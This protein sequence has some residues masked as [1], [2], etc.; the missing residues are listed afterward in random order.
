MEDR[1]LLSGTPALLDPLMVP[2]FVNALP[3]PL[4]PSFVYQ[5]TI[6]A[7]GTPHYE[8]GTYQIQEDLGLGLM[9]AKGNPVK[10]TVYGY[11][12]SAATATYPGQTFV[13]QKGQPI[14]VHW[15][16]GL[17]SA[18]H[19]LPVAPTVLGPNSDAIG[20]PY[21]SVDPSTK[22]V[23]FG[24]GIPMVPHVHGGHTPTQYDGTPEQWFTSGGQ[25]GVDNAGTT[26]TYPNDKQAA[27]I[28]YHDPAM[29]I[30]RLNVYAGLGSTS[31]TTP[32]RTA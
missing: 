29:G 9:D 32:T 30:T 4:D 1:Q 8:V 13:V 3:Q 18:Q 26:F 5:P 6:K 22:M 28:W 23:T 24:S 15:T 17:T 11:G 25:Q 27:T 10:T 21:Y 19:I 12:A 16:N 20:N 14:E 2:K 31:S 7:D